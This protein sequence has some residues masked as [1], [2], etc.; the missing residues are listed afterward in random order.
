MTEAVETPSLPSDRSHEL[1]RLAK[2]GEPPIT[3]CCDS[4]GRVFFLRRPNH[5]RTYKARRMSQYLSLLT[6]FVAFFASNPAAAAKLWQ[7]VVSAYEAAQNLASLIEDSLG[8]AI[9]RDA[10][11]ALSEAEEEAQREF[12]KVAG[13]AR[14]PFG[15]G[16]ILRWLL[17]SEVGKQ[18]LPLL[19]SQFGKIGS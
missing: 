4:C 19:M 17:T 13:V 2:D 3:T 16:K 7:A 18:L 14:G 15:N 10:G 8:G 11:A 1:S 5:G 6:S 12:D 9:Q